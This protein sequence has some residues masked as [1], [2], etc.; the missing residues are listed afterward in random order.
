MQQG[1]KAAAFKTSPLQQV[2]V[3]M[4]LREQTTRYT[5]GN[6]V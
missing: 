1:E 5:D 2:E 4:E 3:V 6:D